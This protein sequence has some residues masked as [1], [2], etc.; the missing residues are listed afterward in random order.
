MIS[1][2]DLTPRQIAVASMVARRM[3]TKQIAREMDITERMVNLHISATAYRWHCEPEC[4]E[5]VHVAL[6]YRALVPITTHAAA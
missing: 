3:T 4:D 5:R 1:L 2:N 6:L